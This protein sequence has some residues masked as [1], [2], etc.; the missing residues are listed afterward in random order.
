MSTACDEASA[1]VVPRSLYVHI[2]ICASKCSYCDFFSLPASA[3]ARGAEERLVGAIL[4]RASALSARFG[5]D[6]FET[7]YVGGGTPTLLSPA[8]L[9]RLLSGLARIAVGSDAAKPREWTVE[10]N[11]DSLDPEALELMR[12]KGV[13]R[14]SIGVQSLDA[15][16]LSI[17]GRRHG[18]EAALRAVKLAAGSGLAV[19]ADLI[20]GIPTA[21][22]SPPTRGMEGRLA[23]FARELMG[24]GARHLSIYD[25]TLEEASPLARTRASLDF[26]GEDEAFEARRAAESAL[27]DAGL[28]RYEVSNYA[29]IGAESRHNLAYWK[30]DSYIGVGPGAV[31]TLARRDGSSLRID[32]GRSFDAYLVSPGADAAEEEIDVIDSAFESIMMAFRT[33]FGLDLEAFGERFGSAAGALIGGTL[34][35][36]SSR[37]VPGEPWPG[38]ADSAGP[39]LNGEGLDLLNRFLLDCMVEMGGARTPRA[40]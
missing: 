18:P 20:A 27:R 32:E 37:I 29:A 23:E 39:A 2:P 19:S 13:T 24:A 25:L 35:A 36:W 21:K 3:L 17:L 7:V 12:A 10:A 6:G 26:P 22:G 5:A 16:E 30:M 28:R 38:R 8:S 33:S 40:S 1:F 4:D 14:I 15:G 9:D 34:A 31:S 11:P